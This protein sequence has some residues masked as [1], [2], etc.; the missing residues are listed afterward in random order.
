MEADHVRVRS[1]I[2]DLRGESMDDGHDGDFRLFAQIE[3]QP[4]GAMGGE[5]TNQNIRQGA[6]VVI[7]IRGALIRLSVPIR[8]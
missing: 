6:V 7:F 8:C 5:V 4:Q 3:P 1:E 2:E